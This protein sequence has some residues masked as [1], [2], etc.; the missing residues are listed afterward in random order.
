LEPALSTFDVPVQN[1]DPAHDGLVIAHLTDLHVGMLTPEK[2]IRRAVEMA[3]D[4]SADLVVMTGD[5]V[6]YSKKFLPKMGECLA[7]LRAR[8]GVVTTLGNHDHWMDADGVSSQLRGNGYDVLRNQNVTLEANGRPLS[9][10][11]IDD[12]VT[13][14]HDSARAFYG[15]NRGGTILTLTHCPELADTAASHGAALIVAG[16]T[17]G[18]QIHMKGV[19]ERVYRKIT[20]RRYLG[21]W[22]DVGNSALYVNRGVGQSSVPLRAGKGAQ[23]EVAVFTL[24]RAG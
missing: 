2:K 19:T 3:N 20:K 8:C 21:G 15:V 22:Y 24:R 18:G 14:H 1:L 6:C 13:R 23:S 17:H 16:H 9:V 5:Y 10:V 4:A 11:G 12:A 7:G